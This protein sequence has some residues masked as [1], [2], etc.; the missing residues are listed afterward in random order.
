[1]ELLTIVWLSSPPSTPARLI[2]AT[3]NYE[4][5][6]LCQDLQSEMV[7]FSTV[8]SKNRHITLELL[9]REGLLGVLGVL[10]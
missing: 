4:A 5:L 7:I 9:P 2:R 8:I 10:Q 1:M 6:N 3:H